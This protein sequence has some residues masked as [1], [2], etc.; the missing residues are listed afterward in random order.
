MRIS[1][2]RTEDRAGVVGED[3]VAQGVWEGRMDGGGLWTRFL[4]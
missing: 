1:K 3:L 4:A 2:E